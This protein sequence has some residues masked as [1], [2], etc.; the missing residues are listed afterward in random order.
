[1]KKL[2]SQPLPHFQY[3]TQKIDRLAHRLPLLEKVSLKS[4][5]IIG[6]LALA[7]YMLPQIINFKKYRQLATTPDMNDFKIQNRKEKDFS[8]TKYYFRPNPLKVLVARLLKID[9][10]ENH[11]EMYKHI[12]DT[13][14]RSNLEELYSY[15]HENKDDGS[16]QFTIS[17]KSKADAI[18]AQLQNT[19]E[20]SLKAKIENLAED[21]NSKDWAIIFD[22]LSKTETSEAE[23][24]YKGIYNKIQSFN[25]ETLIDRW[26]KVSEEAYSNLIE[27]YE[28]IK[29]INSEL[30]T[31]FYDTYLNNLI[32]QLDE[33]KIPNYI[34][35]QKKIRCS[36]E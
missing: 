26:I 30:G 35:L 27:Q 17:E 28:L 29:K 3:L 33:S 7:S 10:T 9:A 24:H 14:S 18:M 13:L 4:S 8:Y 6:G 21:S 1:M 32:E 31:K 12:I 25:Q 34:L 20:T 5:K 2:A 22:L 15:L 19:I 16:A 23:K 11:Q 36:K